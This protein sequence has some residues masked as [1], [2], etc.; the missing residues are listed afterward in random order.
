MSAFLQDT[1]LLKDYIGYAREKI[2]PKMDDEAAAI[3]IDAYRDMRR[4][5]K[6]RGQISAYPRQL[7][8]LIRL[9]E[10]RAKVRLSYIV[11]KEDVD[12]AIR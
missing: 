8:S 7:E 5:G 12:E 3:L 1:S 6:G 11:T 2:Q 9:A 4:V 10:A